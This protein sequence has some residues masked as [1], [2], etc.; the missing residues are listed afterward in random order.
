MLHIVIECYKVL[1]GVMRCYM[2]FYKVLEGPVT[3]IRGC[4]QV[5]LSVTH[6]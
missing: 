2:L 1:R 3:R 5:L 4:Y 6:C